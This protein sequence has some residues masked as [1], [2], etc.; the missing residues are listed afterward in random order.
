LDLSY[1]APAAEIAFC[2]DEALVRR[3]VLNLLHNAI[4]YTPAN[5]RVSVFLKQNCDHCEVAISDTG[6]GIPAEAQ[7]HVFER[8]FRVDKARSRDGFLDGSG[9]GLGLSIAKWAAELHGGRIVLDQ[10]DT[11]GTTFVVFLPLPPQ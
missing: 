2:G 1:K 8:F 3:M 10:S 5:G 6:R 9:A 4:K 7:A 11:G